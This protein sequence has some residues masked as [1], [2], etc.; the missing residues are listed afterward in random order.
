MRDV[1]VVA[2][3]WGCAWEW[4]LFLDLLDG[5]VRAVCC[6]GSNGSLCVD[7]GYGGFS[8]GV[9]SELSV[10]SRGVWAVGF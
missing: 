3:E 2:L 8:E 1:G 4:V 6:V 9:V 5:G 7:G 10:I